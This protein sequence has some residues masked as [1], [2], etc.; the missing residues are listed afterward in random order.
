MAFTLKQRAL[1]HYD[2]M[3]RWAEKQPKRKFPFSGDME[4]AIGEEWHS[5][6]C[7]YC[8]KYDPFACFSTSLC[9]LVEGDC[10]GGLWKDMSTRR[11]WS[12]W[13][14]AAKKVRAYIKQHG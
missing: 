2:R 1:K 4:R 6:D 8:Q 3:I 9:P 5:G 10:C 11:T 12:G 14:N 7:P 13:V